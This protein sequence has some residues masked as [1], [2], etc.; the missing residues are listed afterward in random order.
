[1]P[2]LVTGAAGLLGSH[3]TDLLLERGE[4]VRVLLRP[5]EQAHWQANRRV[6]IVRGD[7]ADRSSLAAAVGGVDCVLHCAARTG[8]WGP[9][10]EYE[11][12]NVRGLRTLVEVAMAAGVRRI[13][14]VSSITVHGNDVRGIAD[15]TAPLRV[16]PNPYSRSKV[17]GERLLASLVRD[18]G[19]PVT[20][21]RPGWIYGPRDVASFARFAGMVRQGRMVLIG[22]G[23]NHLPLI[24]ARD[25]AAG[26]L[27]AAERREAAGRAYLLVNDE[28]VTQRQYLTTIAD[29]LGVAP[30]R[31]HVPYAAALLLGAIA[32]SGGRL[33]CRQQP[34]P[35]M[36][37]GVQLLGGNNRFNIRRARDELGFKPRI[38]MH[39]G[40]R[41]SIAWFNAL[42][43]E[44]R[45]QHKELAR[46]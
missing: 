41:E 31:R 5:L 30:P 28:P 35:L 14:H 10:E 33:A 7:L 12:I 4:A 16:E 24:H 15:E 36:R 9:P 26:M 20:I 27:L 13:V 43:E 6:E 23:D 2:A 17:A 18:H 19:A 32:E 40:V 29:N 34:P 3:L 37:Y 22:T 25:V 11:R 42:H 39:E 21:V 8:P 45:E 38:D 44:S 46:W 1:M